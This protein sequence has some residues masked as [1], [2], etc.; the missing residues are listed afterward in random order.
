MVRAVGRLL[1]LGNPFAAAATKLM[2]PLVLFLE[3]EQ[4][5]SFNEQ[6]CSKCHSRPSAFWL[7]LLAFVR[8]YMCVCCDCKKQLCIPH[9]RSHNDKQYGSKRCQNAHNTIGEC[10]GMDSALPCW[11]K[12]FVLGRLKLHER[13]KNCLRFLC[14]PLL[15]AR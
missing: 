9:D 3:T 2:H 10:S 7:L 11:L 5:R 13:I 12:Q 14:G 15:V 8:M 6:R 4:S 1:P